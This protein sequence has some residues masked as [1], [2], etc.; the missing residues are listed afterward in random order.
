MMKRKYTIS[1]KPGYR[2]DNNT[3][4]IRISGKWLSKIG[5]NVGDQIELAIDEKM[6]MISPACVDEVPNVEEEA[7]GTEIH[8]TRFPSWMKTADIIKSIMTIS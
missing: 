7:P 4:Y 2:I 3:P 8:Q 6:I 1:R 5:F